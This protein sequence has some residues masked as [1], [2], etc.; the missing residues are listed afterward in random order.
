MIDCVIRTLE[1]D[2]AADYQI[3]RLRGLREHPEAF[4]SSWE[5]EVDRPLAWSQRRLTTDAMRPHDVFLGAFG[6]SGLLGVVGLVGRYRPKES[7]NASLVGMY[8]PLELA[9]CGIGQ[10]LVQA[11]VAQARDWPT[12]EQIDLT[13]TAGNG[14][15]QVLYE[16]VGFTVVGV[17]PCAIKVNGACLDKVCMQLRLR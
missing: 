5:R 14:R 2:D 17:M 9:G 11:I 8:V 13:V 6:V 16:R 1:P 3:L 15:A 7:H 12:L 4:T 10:A